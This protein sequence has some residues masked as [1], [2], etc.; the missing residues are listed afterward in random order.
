MQIVIGNRE[1][2]A[3]SVIRQCVKPDAW[4]GRLNLWRMNLSHSALTDWGLAR[5]SIPTRG[6]ILDVGCGGGRTVQK[7]A[8]RAP[9]AKVHGLD[10]SE[11]SV[12]ASQRLNRRALASR[13]VEVHLGSVSQLPFPDGVFGLVTAVETHYYWPDLPADVREVWRVLKPGGSLLMVSE[14][15]K[16]GKREATLQHM[17]AAMRQVTPFAR[18]SVGEHRELLTAGGFVHVEVF[19]EYGKGWLCAIGKK[20]LAAGGRSRN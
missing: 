4:M 7:L 3:E 1:K 19:E 14:A 15:Y 11:T 10:Y 6:A 9:A 8:A 20:P 5:V 13:R 18:P 12:A 2:A 16:G 17:D